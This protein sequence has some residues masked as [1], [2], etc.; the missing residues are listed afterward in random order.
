MRLRDVAVPIVAATIVLAGCSRLT[1]VKPDAQRKGIERVAPEYDFRETS[2]GKQQAAARRLLA[3]AERKLQA[4][5]ASAAGVD[6][7][8]ALKADPASP[9]AHAMLG[10]IARHGGDRET[11][12]KHY[13]RAVELAPKDA[14]ALGNYGSWL[15]DSGRAA[16]S[17][18]WFDKA[19]A[20]S[21]GDRREAMLANAGACALAAG[22]SELAEQASR[23][24]LQADPEN[25]VAL[26]TMAEHNYAAANYL[27]ARA[28]SQRR[29]A[30][31]P[32]TP[33]ALRLASQIEEK[34][35]DTVA[36]TRYV[37][38]L[39]T[40]FPQAWTANPGENA[41]P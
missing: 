24:V 25:A 32:A 35:G 36:A 31:A 26:G 3:S 18:D 13:A 30:A 20:A 21:G 5:D 4:G 29:L 6:A 41:Q 23:A 8:A 15:C 40:E 39:R 16:E 10:L 11:A 9:Q 28:F 14:V 7:R 17:L 1:F 33:D 22:R 38:R 34:L 19:L 2:H 12:G 27:E 37:Q